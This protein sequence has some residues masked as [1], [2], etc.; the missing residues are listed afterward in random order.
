MLGVTPDELEGVALMHDLGI[1]RPTGRSVILLCD[2]ASCWIK[3]CGCILERLES[4]LGVTL[5]QTTADGRFTLLPGA[6]LGACDHAPV[7]MIGR[8]LFDDLDPDKLESIL[9]WYE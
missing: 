9:D 1:R 5:G 6:C 2:G 8:E 4:T 7:M 3:G